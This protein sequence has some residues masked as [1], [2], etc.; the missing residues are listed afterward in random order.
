MNL[1]AT[2]EI[3]QWTGEATGARAKAKLAGMPCVV[4][5][6]DTDGMRQDCT[7]CLRLVKTVFEKADFLEL[8]RLNGFYL[9]YVQA[10][11]TA[12]LPYM[13]SVAGML[14]YVSIYDGRG[15]M[16]KRMTYEPAMD[17]PEGFIALVERWLSAPPV[18]KKPVSPPRKPWWAFWAV[19]ALALTPVALMAAEA[20]GALKEVAVPDIATSAMSALIGKY[21]ANTVVLSSATVVFVQAIKKLIGFF[22]AGLAGGSNAKWLVGC[23]VL[24]VAIVDACLDGQLTSADWVSFA[25]ALVAGVA[26]Y[27]GY[28]PLFKNPSVPGPNL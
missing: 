16:L 18:P 5:A 11:T 17:T 14:P 13:T 15:V 10:R 2:P 19:L 22:P 25:Q 4:V 9:A 7:N 21:A 28:K 3:G 23:T 6:C 8:A 12:G 1:T 24:L 27:F 20:A 26:A